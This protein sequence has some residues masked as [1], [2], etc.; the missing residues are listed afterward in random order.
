MAK[1][2][3]H[4]S[5]NVQLHWNPQTHYSGKSVD[6]GPGS[7]MSKPLPPLCAPYL[8]DCTPYPLLEDGAGGLGGGGGNLS[9]LQLIINM[10]EQLL[11]G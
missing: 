9:S 2:E 4:S 11:Y 5:S 1:L 10:H 8:A 7:S 6:M 3:Q